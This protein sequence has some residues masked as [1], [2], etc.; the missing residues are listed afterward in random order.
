[1]SKKIASISMA[2]I[3]VFMFNCGKGAGK[4]AKPLNKVAYILA[5]S[6]LRMR[7]RPSLN[8][9]TLGAIPYRTR[10]LILREK[11][12]SIVLS[13]ARGKWSKIQWGNTKGWVF[14]GF[15][16]ATKPRIVTKRGPYGPYGR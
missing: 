14:G 15:L 8:G 2:V 12:K 5:K 9:T 3:L 7:N 6:G 4:D 1:M 16:T 10:I 11:G 13:G